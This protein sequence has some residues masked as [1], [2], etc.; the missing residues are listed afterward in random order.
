VGCGA[1]QATLVTVHAAGWLEGGLTLG[2]E[3]FIADIEALQTLAE[4]C[5]PA[6]A[7]TAA[8]GFDA[9]A[10][11]P[12]GGHFFSTAHTMDRYQTAFYRPLVADLSNHG[13]W[14]EAGAQTADQR[15]TAIWKATL[16]G[17]TQPAACAGMAER[18]DP[19]VRRRIAEGGA[20]PED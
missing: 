16:A 20:Q 10:E 9:I 12:P 11:V 19:F 2:Y 5:H 1:A 7:D 6:P 13:T 8:L 15:A 3:K 14:T 4:L 17:F 18:L